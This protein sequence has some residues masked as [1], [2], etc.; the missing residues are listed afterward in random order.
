[1]SRLSEIRELV[2]RELRS[3]PEEMERVR[4]V[5]HLNGVCL[6][7][8][9]ISAKRGVHQE[10]AQIAAMLHDI[11]AYTS[12]SYEDH[13]NRSAARAKT[14]LYEMGGM[15]D[16]EIAQICTAIAKHDDKHVVDGPLE[17]VLKDADV[18]HH[19]LHD[20]SKKVKDKEK[21]RYDSLC[22]EFGLGMRA[23]NA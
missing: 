4:A 20:P 7:A 21:A 14:L 12:G 17:E 3:M 2:Y 11:A 9:L 1:M 6:A 18:I 10:L 22:Q 5:V 19:T 23:T 15:R 16:D 8:A 13:A